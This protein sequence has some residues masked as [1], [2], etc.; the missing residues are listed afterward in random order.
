MTAV[1]CRN[2]VDRKAETWEKQLAPFDRLEFAV[3]DA[4]KGI[5]SALSQIAQARRDDPKAPVL[6]HG[7]DVFHTVMEARRVLAQ[8]WRRVEAAW[9]KA[10]AADLEVDRSK[11]QGIDARGVARSAQ[12]AWGRATALFEQAERL[13][14]AWRRAHAAL[15]LFR[16]DG[17]LNDRGHARV[18]IAE[19]LKGLT[20]TDWSKVRNFLN[21]PRSLSVLDRMQRRLELAEPEAGRRDAMA[22]RW[23]LWHRRVP[24]PHPLMRLVRAVGR[25]CELDEAE[26]ASSDRVSAVLRDTFRAS[27]AVECMNSVL[28]MQQSRHKVMTQPML[29]LKRLYWN[30][31]EF[32]DVP[33]KKACSYQVLGLELPTYDLWTLLQTDPMELTQRLSTAGN[34]G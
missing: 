3:S 15:D 1:F 5:G 20:G 30:C 10:E 8:D 16:A 27:S 24:C 32:R 28:R 2:T 22:W 21:D 6:E 34:G 17:Q 14:T 26:Q 13:E 23:W 33:R 4:A 12:V 29:D 19:A 7:L 31:H 11:R 18:D 25:E 9:E